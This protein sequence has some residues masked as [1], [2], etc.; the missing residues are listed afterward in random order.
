MCGLLVCVVF[1]FF[2]V[3]VWV[4]YDEEYLF[5]VFGFGILGV[6]CMI[7]EEVEFVC[8]IF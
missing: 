8:D 2:F 4:Y 6:V 5:I 1:V 3:C 7:S